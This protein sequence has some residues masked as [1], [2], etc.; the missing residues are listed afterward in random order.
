M[1][2]HLTLGIFSP[3]MVNFMLKWGVGGG[4]VFGDDL[5]VCIDLVV[6]PVIIWQELDNICN[7]AKKRSPHGRVVELLI[8]ILPVEGSV[9]EDVNGVIGGPAVRI[10]ARQ[11]QWVPVKI[12]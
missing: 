6:D 7:P 8:P 5:E 1:A 3:F 2:Y 9:G 12:G 10:P 4:E 11:L